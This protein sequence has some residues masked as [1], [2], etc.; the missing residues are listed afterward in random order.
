MSLISLQKMMCYDAWT[1]RASN[2][3]RG[4]VTYFLN[5]RLTKT[6]TL[7]FRFTKTIGLL[8][9]TRDVVVS[10]SP[11]P[12]QSFA[13]RMSEVHH[14]LQLGPLRRSHQ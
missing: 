3:N 2:T 9:V 6:N 1:Q 10:I 11:R 12:S 14:I 7:V 8:I 4:A 5:V 13:G